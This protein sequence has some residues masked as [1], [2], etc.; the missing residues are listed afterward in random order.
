MDSAKIDIV[1]VTPSTLRD[2]HI[3]FDATWLD[4]MANYTQYRFRKENFNKSE[5]YLLIKEE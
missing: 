5:T 1:I 3:C 4:F 2:P